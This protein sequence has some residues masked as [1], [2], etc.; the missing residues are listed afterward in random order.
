[1]RGPVALGLLLIIGLAAPGAGY[2]QG[3][4]HGPSGF[5]LRFEFI[6]YQVTDQVLNNL[7]HQGWFPSLALQ[8]YRSS[9]SVRHRLELSIQPNLLKS[10]YDPDRS[11]VILDHS[12]NYSYARLATGIGTNVSL[13]LGGIVGLTSHLGYYENWDDSHGYWLT[14]YTLGLD[15]TLVRRFTNGGSL[16]LTA[17]TPVVALVSRPFDRIL[18]K[19]WDA[20]FWGIVKKLHERARITTLHEHLVINAALGYTFR[21]TTGFDQ[22]VMWRFS[23]TS[24]TMSYSKPI[25]RLTHS[26]GVVLL[27]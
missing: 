2:Q 1:M 20:T 19:T 24:N 13:Y 16:E 6:D 18:S 22:R 10:R 12:L 4:V 21:Y 9:A 15:A 25:H 8:Y 17:N 7:R 14:A 26:L 23:Y 11:S 5:A 27:F 3:V